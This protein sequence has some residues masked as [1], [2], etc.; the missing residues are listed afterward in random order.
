MIVDGPEGVEAARAA[1]MEATAAWLI[2]IALILAGAWY[3]YLGAKRRGR[4]RVT[5]YLA[6]L[7]LIAIGFVAASHERSI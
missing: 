4:G 6:A 3:G 1:G 7:L 2:G 5:H